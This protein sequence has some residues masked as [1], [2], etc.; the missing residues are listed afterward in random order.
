MPLLYQKIKTLPLP[1]ATLGIR[2]LVIW[3]KAAREQFI[4]KNSSW[5]EKLY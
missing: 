3:K 5:L 1:E 4:T 2:I